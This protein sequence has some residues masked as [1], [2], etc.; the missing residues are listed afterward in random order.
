MNQRTESQIRRYRKELRAGLL[1]LGAPLAVIGFWAVIAP[2]SWFDEFPGGGRHWVSAIGPYNEHLASDVGAF[3]LAISG[4]LVFAALV[5]ER[6]LVQAALG[7]L[8]VYSVPHLIY[9][10]TEL[11]AYGTQDKI[12][13]LISLSL[14]VVLPL[15]ML[16]L[17]REKVQAGPAV[18]APAMKTKGEVTYGTR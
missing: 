4:L 13:N 8:L 10:I 2:H 15:V 5:L 3:F 18:T 1:A 14:I 9:H 17:A 12:L 7:T 16:A 11:D 6:R